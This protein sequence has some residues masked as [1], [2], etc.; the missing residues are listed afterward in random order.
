[1][2]GVEHI[3]LLSRHN[4][5]LQ[6]LFRCVL[7]FSKFVH[8]LYGGHELLVVNQTDVVLIRASKMVEFK[9]SFSCVVILQHG[10]TAAH[11]HFVVTFLAE[12]L[13]AC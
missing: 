5:V 4:K 7:S 8:F 13:L 12:Y 9:S 3:T 11:R 6:K 1:M 10:Q 2:W